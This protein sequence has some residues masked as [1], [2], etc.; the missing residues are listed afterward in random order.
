MA[1]RSV[2]R[3]NVSTVPLRHERLRSC[4]QTLVCLWLARP[5][6]RVQR[7]IER[8][9]VAKVS[10]SIGVLWVEPHT[11]AMLGLCRRA[12]TLP[13]CAYRKESAVDGHGYRR[14][15]GHLEAVVG[16]SVAER[17]ER[18]EVS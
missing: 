3:V 8:W 12:A 9:V 18:S 2:K 15:K 7:P 4:V 5:G 1:F 16:F 13:Y 10:P 6:R 11:S 17:A 14:V